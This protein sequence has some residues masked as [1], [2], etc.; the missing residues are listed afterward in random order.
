MKEL[1]E[2]WHEIKPQVKEQWIDFGKTVLKTAVILGI[3]F[4]MIYLACLL[5]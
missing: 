2:M 5:G 4:T 1:A 3:G